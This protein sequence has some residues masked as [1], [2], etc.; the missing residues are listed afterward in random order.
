[1]VIGVAGMAII[2]REISMAVVRLCGCLGYSGDQLKHQ[3][4]MVFCW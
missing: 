1:M 2:V 4:V 3:S